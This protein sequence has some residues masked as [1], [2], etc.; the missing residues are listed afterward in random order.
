MDKWQAINQFWN[1]FGVSAYD[2]NSVPDEAATPYITYDA[3]IGALGDVLVLTASIWDR[4]T[5]W[6]WISNK[7]DEIAQAIGGYKSMKIDGGYVWFVRG[8]PFAQRMSDPDDDMI[9]RVY[10]VINAEFLTAH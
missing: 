2:E 6:Q 10:L 5:S 8:E 1:S 4:S 7:A 3:H 9:R